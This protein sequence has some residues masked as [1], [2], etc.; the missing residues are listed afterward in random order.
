MSIHTNSP[1]G[2]ELLVCL[3]RYFAASGNEQI[4]E[5]NEYATIAKS[6]SSAPPHV[7]HP[8]LE[9]VEAVVR[10][11]RV[12]TE[13]DESLPVRARELSEEL[14]GLTGLMFG[15]DEL[16]ERFVSDDA[17]LSDPVW[18][19]V[20]NIAREA[21]TFFLQKAPEVRIGIWDLMCFVAD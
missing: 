9:L 21:L 17:L 11:L 13:S 12:E 16:T 1:S 18:S 14:D 4:A 7:Q 10:H 20:R 2:L 3:L 15:R 6:K 19:I 8:L 5:L